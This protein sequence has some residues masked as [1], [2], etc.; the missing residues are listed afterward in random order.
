MKP[1]GVHS[2]GGSSA[3]AGE[4]IAGH[5]KADLNN[6]RFGRLV[7]LAEMGRDK[8]GSVMWECL[9][10]CGNL[11]GRTTARLRS[12]HVRSCGCLQK[13]AAL[14]NV[15]LHHARV[16]THG[17]GHGNYSPTYKTWTSMRE[18]AKTY[19]SQ[20]GKR[21]KSLGITVCDRWNSFENFLSDMGE[22]PVGKS[23]DRINP[24][25]NYEKSNCRW[26]TPKEQAR[27][28]VKTVFIDVNGTKMRAVEFAEQNGI[29]KEIVYS[30]LR[31]KALLEKM[32]E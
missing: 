6:E 24:L 7:V 21:Y 14:N 13:E 18:R 17:L 28:K 2:K 12:G 16:K 25:G 9:C 4:N 11:V 32:N 31:V 5:N 15:R 20:S 29:E 8:H 27:N 19:S 22:K 1:R 26:A 30:Y 3:W 10:D 23:I